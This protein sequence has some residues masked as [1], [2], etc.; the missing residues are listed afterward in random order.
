MPIPIR[1][2]AKLSTVQVP[3]EEMMNTTMRSR[4]RRRMSR[5]FAEVEHSLS[6]SNVVVANAVAAIVDLV[7]RRSSKRTYSRMFRKRNRRSARNIYRELGKGYCRRVY[8]MKFGTFKRLAT[9]FRPYIMLQCAEQVLHATLDMDKL[10]R[11]SALLVPFV[12]QHMIL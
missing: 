7:H 3:I 8:R 11:M 12:G 6:V 4:Q 5:S 9:N 1:I 2:S 10:H